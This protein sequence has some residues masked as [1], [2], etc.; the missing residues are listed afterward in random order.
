MDFENML[1]GEVERIIFQNLEN[2]Y[3]VLE[4]AAEDELHTVTGV[5]PNVKAGENI[6]VM[7]SF[8]THPSFGIQFNAQA[9]EVV[10]PQ[11]S[12]AILRYL[13]SGAVKGIGPA[14]AAKLVREFGEN[15]LYV[16]ENEPDRISAFKGISKKKA[17]EISEFLK[18]ES[19]MREM[20]L[21][22]SKYGVSP[23]E[24]AKIWKM[25]GSTYLERIE[26]NPY[27]LCSDILGIDFYRADAIAQIM[28]RPID[29]INRIRAGIIYVLKH[30]LSNGH[31]CLP[32]DKLV[33]AASRLLNI[34]EDLVESVMSDLIENK[35]VVAVFYNEIKY[36]YLERYFRAEEY[37]AARLNLIKKYPA[38]PIYQ[39]ENH[40]KAVEEASEIKYA[41][42]Q[43]EAIRKALL[44][45]M[46]ILTGGP[47]TGK[48]TTL[49][50]II[51]ILKEK[52]ETV[53]LA[54][55]TGRAAK[56]MSELTGEEAK[57]IHRLLQVEWDEE[58]RPVFAKNEKNLL[59]CDALVLDEVSMIDA[60]LFESVLKALPLGCRL[61]LVG[62]SDQLPS[63]AAGNVLSDLIAADVIPMVAL[64][65]IFR[66]A[67][68]S[69]IVINA[70]KVV[71]GETPEL[72][73]K[74]KDFFFMPISRS[75]N[76]VSTVL[77]LC[78]KRLPD[79]YGFDSV[80]DIQVLCPGRKGEVGTASMNAYLQ[81]V[82]NPADDEKNELS[83]SGR[84]F[85]EGDKVIQTKNNYNLLWSKADGTS[86]EG[87]FNGDIG[88]IISIDKRAAC[89]VVS[90]DDR[91]VS[92]DFEQIKELE[93]AYALTVHKSQ[94]NEFPAV[95]LPLY[96]PAPQLVYR[97]LLY[98]A[99]T[100]AKSLLIIVG[101]EE[102]IHKMIENDRKT[103][104]YSGLSYLIKDE[105]N[106]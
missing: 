102:V 37:I 83:V 86:G 59:E 33:S 20:L 64:K 13:S 28:E 31:T 68:Q 93:H 77:S 76:I 94:G 2:G 52:G 14:T 5:M 89:V 75:E 22:L 17:Q 42:L 82:L 66:Q 38:S 99:I 6:T 84:I 9:Y 40:I 78:S 95:I 69:L 103:R 3:T 62:D 29:N 16:M 26:E 70:H 73:D 30:N 54:A 50:A 10:R 57:T 74:T 48:T 43:K 41:P 19:G 96:R 32:N 100:R 44:E 81:E 11:S 51:R 98:T 71:N 72:F 92:Y 91:F 90:M 8:K 53:F 79:A 46:L 1:T 12:E 58:D 97:N 87:I 56:R 85:R 65:D 21:Y 55:P 60:L 45:G 88:T 61:I 105:F 49:E 104:R 7:G 18:A 15:T 25:Y 47:G 36:I 39:I 101:D 67:M 63:V 23:N 35:Y 24:A 34:E 80:F 4:L 106:G 27:C